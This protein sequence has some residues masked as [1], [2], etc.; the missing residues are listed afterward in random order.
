MKKI[1]KG[2]PGYL[3]YKK[4]VEIIRTIIYFALV[5]AVFF[6]G[7]S[8][9]HTKKNLL[10][11]VAILGCLP[12]S[13]A[14]VGVI[15]RF[16]YPSIASIRAEEIKDKTGYITAIYDMI[17]TSREKVM[18]MDCIVISGNTIFG[19]TN[20]EKVDVK[21]AASHIR[22]ILNQNQF[23]DVSVKILN[24]YTAFLARAEGL[25]SIAA[26]EKSDT[27]ELEEQMAHVILNISM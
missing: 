23:P 10:T 15:T 17:I 9:A 18:P 12:A 3:D 14:L 13:K 20:S 2:N 16:P 22:G 27:K 24:N 25:N 19:Y 7:Y 11:I 1:I 8:Q 4:K 6:L 21:Y 5:A 26:V